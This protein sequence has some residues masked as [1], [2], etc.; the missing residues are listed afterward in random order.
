[1]VKTSGG[2]NKKLTGTRTTFPPEDVSLGSFTLKSCIKRQRNVQ[3][4][5]A[6][7]LKLFFAISMLTRASLLALAKSIY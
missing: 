4:K 7:D 3:K 5:S 2:E 6:A 1:M